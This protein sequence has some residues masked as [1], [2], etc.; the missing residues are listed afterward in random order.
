MRSGLQSWAQGAGSEG[1]AAEAEAKAK[2][3]GGA[4]SPKTK[5]YFSWL[6]ERSGWRHLYACDA[7]TGATRALTAGAPRKAS[8]R[9]ASA[10]PWRSYPWLPSPSPPMCAKGAAHARKTLGAW[11]S[12]AAVRLAVCVSWCEF[13]PKRFRTQVAVLV[14]VRHK[15]ND[16]FCVVYRTKPRTWV[17]SRFGHKGPQDT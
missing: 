12:V 10:P 8:P 6:S 1:G 4:S 14:H 16:E 13:E 17:L 9:L 2:T 11:L 3:V 5:R 15:V 7:A